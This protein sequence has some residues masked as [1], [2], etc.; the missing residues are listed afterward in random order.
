[1]RFYRA[2]D[3]LPEGNLATTD[4]VY[5]E[6]PASN[7][8]RGARLREGDLM[9][10]ITGAT[11]GRVSVFPVGAEP[12]FVSQHVAICRLPS[13]KIEPRFAL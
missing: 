12:G 3:L 4:K 11:V 8:G 9:L 7:Q 1:M 13:E 10:V 2:Q 5:I 6:Q